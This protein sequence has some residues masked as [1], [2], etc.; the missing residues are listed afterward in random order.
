[1][2]LKDTAS[3]VAIL[4]ALY[5][6]IG[7]ELKDSKAELNAELREAKEQTGAQKISVSIPDGTDVGTVSLVQPKAAAMVVDEKAFLKWVQATRPDEVARRFV[8][9][10]RPAWQALILK[11][12]TAAGVAQWC[13]PDTGE[14]HD[15]P[16]V[17]MQGRAAYTRMT[18][19]DAGRAAIAAAWRDGQ[20]GATV[21]P[22]LTAGDQS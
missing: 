3:R 4:T 20:L 12:I 2:S 11:E 19:P 8:T 9:E 7:A 14:L 5:D 16:G 13:D 21:L 18:L 15:V 17:A 22:Q 10:V 6:A 1:M